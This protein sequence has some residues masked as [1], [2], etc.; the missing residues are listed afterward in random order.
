[1]AKTEQ[2]YLNVAIQV[3]EETSEMLMDVTVS[4]GNSY[5]I[6]KMVFLQVNLETNEE[7]W[8][9]FPIK[10]SPLRLEA[11][12][13]GIKAGIRNAKRIDDYSKTKESQKYKEIL[14]TTTRKMIVKSDLY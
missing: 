5:E 14:D 8:V 13:D 12:K 7:N 2:L 9:V 1:M 6:N 4:K 3:A 10:Y 11:L